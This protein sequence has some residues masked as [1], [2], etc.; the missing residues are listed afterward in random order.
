MDSGIQQ[1]PVSGL[2]VVN[3]IE[4]PDA[5]RKLVTDRLGLPLSVCASEE[6]ARL[7]ARGPNDD[8]P[9]GPAIIGQGRTVLHKV[10]AED[11]DEKLNRRTI[12]R[13]DHGHQ[14]KM[15]QDSPPSAPSR[16]EPSAGSV[17]CC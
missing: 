17:P 1:L 9:L 3:A 6:N 15:R 14:V 5:S 2:E 11:T 12:V 8:P 10:E 13:D 16:V 7:T 4:Q